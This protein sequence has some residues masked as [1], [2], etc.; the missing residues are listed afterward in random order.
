MVGNSRLQ[1]LQN[2]ETQKQQPEEI[3][4]QGYTVR[5]SSG[6]E[7]IVP[8]VLVDVEI[9]LAHMHKPDFS[10]AVNMKVGVSDGSNLNWF[11][12]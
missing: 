5:V 8:T 2:A 10:E 11:N 7:V 12:I 1:S 6:Q 4:K 3:I 9:P